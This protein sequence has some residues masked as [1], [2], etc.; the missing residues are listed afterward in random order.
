VAT[1]RV[2]FDADEADWQKRPDG[3]VTVDL[4]GQLLRRELRLSGRVEGPGC[5]EFNVAFTGPVP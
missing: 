1:D 2:R 3:Y 4:D 5:T